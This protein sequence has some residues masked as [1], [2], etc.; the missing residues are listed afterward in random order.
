MY[1]Y[2]TTTLL[3]LFM[4]VSGAM[5]AAWMGRL[6]TEKAKPLLPF[7]PFNCRPCLT[8]HLTWLLTGCTTLWF[9][10]IGYVNRHN[11]AFIIVCIILGACLNFFVALKNIKIAP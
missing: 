10:N 6:F 8:F 3:F 4:L 7:K 5:A 9:G 11:A 2:H 1:H